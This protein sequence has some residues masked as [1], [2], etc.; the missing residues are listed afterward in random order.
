M[1]KL[2]NFHY[3]HLHPQHI[4]P[5]QH[6]FTYQQKYYKLSHMLNTFLES[7][8]T[9]KKQ[10][11]IVLRNKLHKANQSPREQ[12]TAIDLSRSFLV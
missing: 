1:K 8:T 2:F 12:G 6:A 5:V 7:I 9:T 4:I 10:T 11:K 3:R